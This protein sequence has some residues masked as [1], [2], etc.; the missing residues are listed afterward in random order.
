[1]SEC[2]CVCCVCACVCACLCV[3]RLG[4]RE[5]VVTLT[6]FLHSSQCREFSSTHNLDCSSMLLRTRLKQPTLSCSMVILSDGS[7]A[8]LMVS[9]CVCVFICTYNV[10]I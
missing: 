1:M 8:A 7:M 4:R 3:R 9:V 10:V 2:V 5:N 6:T